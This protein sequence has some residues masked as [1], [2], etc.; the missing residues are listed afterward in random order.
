MSKKQTKKTKPENMALVEKDNE[1]AGIPVNQ[2]IPTAEV[3]PMVMM[4]MAVA[5]GKDVET[6]ERLWALNEKVEAANARKAFFAA[7]SEFK[8]SPPQVIK[9]KQNSQYGDS[10]YVSI[11]NMVTTASEEMGKHGLTHS[12]TYGEGEKGEIICTC[13]MSHS[14]GHQESVTL[15]SPI[16]ESGKKNPLQG[17]KSTRTYL[18]L[19][20]F[21]AVTGMVSV[22]GNLDDDGNSFS[23]PE[24]TLIGESEVNEL[25][26]LLVENEIN[27]ETFKEWL[28]KDMGI[29]TLEQVATNQFVRVRA[30]INASI[31]AKNKEKK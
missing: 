26:S 13:I 2:I 4:Q 23:Q 16:D 27:R 21:E 7:L 22:E 11:G 1:V 9:D 20:T 12:W 18:K 19:E 6:M 31:K 14:L 25:D 17:R 15:S 5:Q 3:T 28:F 10:A 29:E 24:I 8:K 30:A